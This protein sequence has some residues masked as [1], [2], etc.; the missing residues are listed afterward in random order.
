MELTGIRK[1]VF[2]DRYAIKD[3]S[4]KPV[5]QTPKE[6]WRRVARAVSLVEKTKDL[7]ATWE[8]KFYDAAKKYGGD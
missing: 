3:E 2:L 6:M 1:Q 7:K 8:Q 4:G 5:E